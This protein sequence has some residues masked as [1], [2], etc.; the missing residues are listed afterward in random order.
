[1]HMV[2]TNRLYFIIAQVRERPTAEFLEK[3]SKSDLEF[4][5]SIKNIFVTSTSKV[6][7]QP[8]LLDLLVFF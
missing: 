1:M 3:A 8:P 4:G 7:P 2:H 6:H 5:N